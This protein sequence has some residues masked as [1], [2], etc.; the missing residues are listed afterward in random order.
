MEE[1]TVKI[2][3]DRDALDKKEGR[4]KKNI[5][6]FP[7]SPMTMS[8]MR[9]S[10]IVIL[11][12][13]YTATRGRIASGAS[14]RYAKAVGRLRIIRKGDTVW[15]DVVEDYEAP[16]YREAISEKIVMYKP[17]SSLVSAVFEPSTSSTSTIENNLILNVVHENMPIGK[18]SK[19]KKGTACKT[20]K[21]DK[22]ID[23]MYKLG[24]P[25]PKQTSYI[26]NSDPRGTTI[27][28]MYSMLMTKYLK[29]PMVLTE[30]Q[31]WRSMIDG[32]YDEYKIRYFYYLMQND[33]WNVEKDT[34]CRLIADYMIKNPEKGSLTSQVGGS[35][36][37]LQIQSLLNT[38]RHKAEIDTYYGTNVVPLTQVS[39][40]MAQPIKFTPLPPP[41]LKRY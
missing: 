10:P 16:S 37:P 7:Q 14:A 32:R 24:M 4:S 29:D 35:Y 34:I 39:F 3:T 23:A 15:R 2:M 41:Q 25:V 26:F 36:A 33:Y 22:L 40:S 11:H 21:R 6:S 27:D 17:K 5:F 20:L 8:Q 19:E 1:P 9:P 12:N 28:T 30:A 18:R 38:P 13:L 31:S